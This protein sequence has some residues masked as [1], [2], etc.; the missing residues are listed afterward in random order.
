MLQVGR[1]KQM[2]AAKRIRQILIEEDLTQ[3]QFAEMIKP[4]AGA[5]AQQVR[6]TLTRDS[7][8]FSTLEEWLDVLGYDIVFISRK[9]GKQ[10]WP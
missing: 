5:N 1:E 9:S 7:F 2:G 4:E 3:A 10:F 6:D 8:R